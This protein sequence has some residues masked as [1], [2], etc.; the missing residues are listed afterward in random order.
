MKNELLVLF[1]QLFCEY[2]FLHIILEAVIKSMKKHILPLIVLLALIQT[3]SAFALENGQTSLPKSGEL[4]EKETEAVAPIDPQAAPPLTL[5]ITPK[6]FFGARLDLEARG[7]NNS[8]L[9][10]AEE[11]SLV[12]LRSRL[13]LAGLYRPWDNID[14]Y[15]EVQFSYTHILEDPSDRRSNELQFALS[16]AYM[17]WKEFLTPSLNLQVGRQRFK[18]DREWLYDENLDAVRTFFNRDPF[19]LELSVS[20][21]LVES[22]FSNNLIEPND[23]E[24]VIINY[25]LYNAYRYGRKDEIAFYG[26]VRQDPSEDQDLAFVGIYWKSRSIKDQKFWIHAASSLGFEESNSLMGSGVDLG[27][28]SRFD[29][30]LEPSL[31]MGFALGSKNFR[32]TGLEDNNGR[33]NGVVKFRYYG[34]VLDPELSNIMIPTFGL[35]VIPFDRTSLDIVYHYYAQVEKTD[36]LRDADV[37]ED[38]TGEDRDLGH[39]VD[40]IFGTEIIKNVQIEFDAG[41]FIPGKAFPEDDLA[42]LGKLEFLIAF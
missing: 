37:D 4:N 14:F 36:E 9:N 32:Q 15:G 24:D 31:T 38:L 23:E 26:I 6:L 3:P 7:D 41:V 18:D 33:F 28:I 27:W 5:K 39:E 8:D 16:R 22:E 1:I 42:Y 35:G 40:L 30:W 21:N 17:L 12:F 2:Q 13:N 11:D 19:S 34:E 10:D 25:I 29:L 20:A